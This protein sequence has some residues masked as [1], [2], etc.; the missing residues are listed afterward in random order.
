MIVDDS[1]FAM[2]IGGIGL[3]VTEP[4]AALVFRRIIKAAARSDDLCLRELH[5]NRLQPKQI[6]VPLAA[7]R[8][9]QPFLSKESAPCAPD[10]WLFTVYS[11]KS[12]DV[13]IARHR[14][15]A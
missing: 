13:G 12:A 10:E 11:R 2:M 8:N 1:L 4:K 3:A 5:A 7:L 15:P 6:D 14:E 9:H